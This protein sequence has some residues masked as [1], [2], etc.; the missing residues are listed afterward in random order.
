MD[1]HSPSLV[2]RAGWP[3]REVRGWLGAWVDE[4]VEACWP[5]VP[6]H[7]KTRRSRWSPGLPSQRTDLPLDSMVSCWGR[8]EAV[9]VL[10]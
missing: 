6:A 5:L 7:S 2:G 4:L 9:Q 3:R 8:R 1:V 10:A